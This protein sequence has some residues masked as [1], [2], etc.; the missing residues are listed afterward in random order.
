METEYPF[1]LD[2]K[3]IERFPLYWCLEPLQILK[4]VERS[5]EE[6]M[7]LEYV[8]ECFVEGECLSIPELLIFDREND[9]QGLE[10]YIGN[11]CG[12]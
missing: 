3:L 12:F 10:A 8:I 9:K 11:A 1:Y 7:F 4:V 5:E 6:N 2:N